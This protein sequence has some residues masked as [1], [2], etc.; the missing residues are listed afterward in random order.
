MNGHSRGTVGMEALGAAC[1][2]L[3]QEVNATAPYGQ[4]V[5]F[6]HQS[7]RRPKIHGDAVSDYSTPNPDFKK[8]F[9]RKINIYIY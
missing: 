9:F 6:D 8:S 4:R 7:K 1:G 2:H 3:H 5:R